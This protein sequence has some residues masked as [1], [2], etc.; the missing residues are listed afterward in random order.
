MPQKLTDHQKYVT[1]RE[2]ERILGVKRNVFFYY[3][4]SGQIEKREKTEKGPSLYKYADILKVK[5]KR[6]SKK[7]K[8]S[9]QVDWM[10]PSDLPAILKLDYTVY[11]EN[12]VGDIGLYVS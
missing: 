8:V 2:G 1:S 10:K 3:V 6:E 9:T 7:R 12:I 11:Q 5:E 4:E